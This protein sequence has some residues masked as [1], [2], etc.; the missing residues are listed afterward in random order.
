MTE[1]SL[2][3]RMEA[4]LRDVEDVCNRGCRGEAYYAAGISLAFLTLVE[5]DTADQQAFSA[6]LARRLDG[7]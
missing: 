7:S 2:A 4:A 1:M 6:E 5:I 3:D